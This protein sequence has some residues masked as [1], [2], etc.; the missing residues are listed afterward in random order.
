MPYAAY[1]GFFAHRSVF[2]QIGLP[3]QE[4][5]L[6]QDDLEYKLRLTKSRGKNFLC[7][8]APID[9][10]EISWENLSRYS[11]GIFAWLRSNEYFRIYYGARNLAYFEKITLIKKSY[12]QLIVLSI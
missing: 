11:F 8:N 12:V 2:H 7:P 3:K 1:G 5:V 9:S 10:Q 6:Y 4:Y